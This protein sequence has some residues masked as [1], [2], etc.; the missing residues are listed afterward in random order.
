MDIKAVYYVLL[1]L[2]IVVALVFTVIVLITGKGDAMSGGGGSVRTT[3]KGKASFDDQISK[4]T[5]IL[6]VSFM[7]LM[8]VLDAVAHQ[9][10]R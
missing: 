7:G 10:F 4:V 1:A 5:L 3:F 2:A 6:G 9:A 8:L